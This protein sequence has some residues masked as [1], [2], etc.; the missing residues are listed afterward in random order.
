MV[1]KSVAQNFANTERYAESNEKLMQTPN[2]GNRIVLMGDSITEFWTNANPHFFEDNPY[3]INRGIGGQTTPQMLGRFDA[4]V[5]AL[6]PKVVV[7]LAGTNDIAGNSGP[8]TISEIMTNIA[9]MAENAK[10][11]HIKVV[12]CSVLPV[13]DYPW[14]PGIIPADKIIALN[15][16]IK[17]YAQQHGMAYL[18][19]FHT[20][21]DGRN[22]LNA[23][24]S[25]DG[26]HPNKKGYKVMGPLLE[27]AIESVMKN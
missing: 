9:A 21:V 5:I 27:K 12:L 2:M 3:L 6:N 8:I 24:Y 7:I 4:D 26:V 25:G 14:K 19:Y 23:K 16:M 10:A 15:T 1:Q 13:F 18:D 11:H 17:A 22:G 20:M